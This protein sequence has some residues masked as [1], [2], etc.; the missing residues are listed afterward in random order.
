MK[1][2]MLSRSPGFVFSMDSYH[3]L[4]II[5]TKININNYIV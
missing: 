3:I 2:G 1:Y 5:D 4:D